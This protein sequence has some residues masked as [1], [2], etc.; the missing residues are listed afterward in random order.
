MP[1]LP[2]VEIIKKGLLKKI[3]GERILDVNTLFSGI[4]KGISIGRFKKEVINRKIIDIRR[5]GKN[6]L[7]FLD[8]GKILVI[9]FKLTGHALVASSDFEVDKEGRWLGENLHPYFL[10]PKNQFIR[11]IFLL[12]S[13]KKLAIS[14]LRK[15]AYIKLFSQKELE[16]FLKEYGP[17]PL[18]KDFSFEVFVK[19]I[20]KSQAPIKKVLMDQKIIA[21]I[22]NI[23]SD[24][25]LFEAKI[26][27][28]T[29]ANNLEK[30]QLKNLYKAI[31]EVLKKALAE[32]GTSISDFRDIEGKKGNYDLL[33]K[34][35]QRK[36]ERCFICGRKIERIKIG[37]RSAHF[38]PN[39]QK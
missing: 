13:N 19:R 28:L 36:G 15:F 7:L 26:N 3:L 18:E 16:R 8:N 22:G 23:Y 37:G 2:E 4:V 20:Q 14:D 35:Y 1:E 12:T 32:K 6:L 24:E 27:P 9:H 33:R 25:A 17:E 38:C 39:C 5:R 30:E 31:I 11:I 29:K 21:G 34:V 10:D